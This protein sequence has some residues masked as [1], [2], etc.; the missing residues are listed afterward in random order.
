MAYSVPYS[1]W[2]N[3]IEEFWAEAKAFYRKLGTKH[4]IESG[5][6]DIRYEA[7]LAVDMVGFVNTVKYARRGLE[8]IQRIN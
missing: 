7:R 8:A 1:P 2:Q 5:E 4:L 3:G 6:R